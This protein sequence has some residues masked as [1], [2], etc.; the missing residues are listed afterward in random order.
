MVV[1]LALAMMVSALAALGL[2]NEKWDCKD[3][4]LGEAIFETKNAITFPAG[5]NANF[6]QLI[7]GNDKA[8]AVEPAFN[9]FGF[10][11]KAE[12]N[13][14]IIK[15]QTT[16][17]NCSPCCSAEV[18]DTDCEACADACSLV[19]VEQV[20]VGDR[21]ALASGPHAFATNNVKIVAIQE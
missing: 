15:K 20:K 14:E 11:P 13:L 3:G 19:N 16:V 10:D 17:D 4:V 5:Q 9:R 21:M 6:D 8:I 1:I 12:N 18:Y 2:A 7:V